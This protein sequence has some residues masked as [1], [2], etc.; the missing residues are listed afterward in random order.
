MKYFLG[1][2]GII[3]LGFITQTFFAWWSI[4][5][6]AAIIGASIK[7]NNAQSYLMGFLGVFLLWG[8]YAAFRNNANDGILAG[9][10]GVLFE[11]IGAF[12]VVLITALLGGI[13]GGFGALTG[14]LGRK[15]LDKENGICR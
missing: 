14:R 6:V 2:L 15:L 4:V 1:V 13:I 10:M 5:L 11:G 7:L 12:Q 8:V 9:K 3:I